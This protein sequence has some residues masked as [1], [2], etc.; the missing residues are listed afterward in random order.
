[1]AATTFGPGARCIDGLRQFLHDFPPSEEN[2]R[3]GWA[4]CVGGVL[5]AW[6]VVARERK[7]ERA[8]ESAGLLTGEEAQSAR[9]SA[10]EAVLFYLAAFTEKKDEKAARWAEIER[11]MAHLRSKEAA[12]T[13]PGHR[14]GRDA[15]A[16]GG[17]AD[18][19]I[20]LT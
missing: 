13:P 9:N 6:D 16:N 18:D 1:M 7:R 20:D 11:H 3:R 19:P 12:A 5:H 10:H 8:S 15:S 4:Q 17:G 14:A 2:V